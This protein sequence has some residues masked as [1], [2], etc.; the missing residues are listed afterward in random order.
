MRKSAAHPLATPLVALVVALAI[1][2]PAA[3]AAPAPSASTG[4]CAELA[5][6]LPRPH[7]CDWPAIAY[8]WARDLDPATF[9]DPIEPAGS[10]EARYFEEGPWS[11]VVEREF[12]CCDSSG[13]GFDIYRPRHLDAPRSRLPIATWGNGSGAQ[14][15]HYDYFLRHVASWGFV[16]V[17]SRE[18][19]TG[20]GTEVLDAARFLVAESRKRS[21]IFY[22]RLARDRVGA[23]GHS[24]G[25][26]GAINAMEK[27][28]GLITTAILF[29]IPENGCWT[30]PPA[31][32]T[33]ESPLGDITWGSVFFV[34][35]SNDPAISSAEG[36]AWYYDELPDSLPKA[37]GRLR[38]PSHGDINGQPGC[39]DPGASAGCFNGVYGYLGYPTA[40]LVDRLYGDQRAR[41]AFID[42]G[43]GEI[44]TNENWDN[45]ASAN[46]R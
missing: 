36:N 13:N 10:V 37:R 42:D 15:E 19:N 23:M 14:P 2:T 5:P 24:Q 30:C 6:D 46:I 29:H 32:P 26:A 20:S 21:S 16:V 17:A 12:G 33:G 44:F 28:E 8:E 22:R 35:G 41:E 43:R 34:T 25:A 4:P 18:E 27:S 1:G 7:P 38:G 9:T 11:V 45:V 40:W 39:R 3:A 31:T